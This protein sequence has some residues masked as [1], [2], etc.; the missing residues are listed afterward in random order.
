MRE[1]MDEFIKYAKEQFG[2]D[3]TFEN[4]STPDT[5]ETLFGASFL[6]QNDADMFFCE[7]LEKYMSY[8]NKNAKVYSEAVDL[9]EN[10][11]EQPEICFAA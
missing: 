9:S 10:F 2:Y 11:E 1:M 5:F 3:I 4:S 8:S 6:K 7:G